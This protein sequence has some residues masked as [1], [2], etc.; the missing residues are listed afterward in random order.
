ML[1]CI[2]L[3]KLFLF[4]IILVCLIERLSVLKFFLKFQLN[5]FCWLCLYYGVLINWHNFCINICDIYSIN[6]RERYSN[7]CHHQT[8]HCLLWKLIQLEWI[9]INEYKI[10][11]IKCFKKNESVFVCLTMK[12]PTHFFMI[13]NHFKM[14]WISDSL[15]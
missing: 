4:V 14:M 5:F 2:I 3:N 15:C 6:A 7:I 1:I 8:D 13:W 10:W 9:Y 11:N 12:L